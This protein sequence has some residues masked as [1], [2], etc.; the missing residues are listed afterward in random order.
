MRKFSIIF[1]GVIAFGALFILQ[2]TYVSAT[3]APTLPPD[4]ELMVIADCDAVNG[5]QLFRVNLN[6]EASKIGSPNLNTGGQC[7]D[8]PTYNPVTKK[9][10]FI[11]FS[12]SA[13]WFKAINVN[14]VSGELTE[15]S[16]LAFP[17][18]ISE[19]WLSYT[20]SAGETWLVSRDYVY[21]VDLSTGIIA[22]F[23]SL[24]VSGAPGV[25]LSAGGIDLTRPN[26][27][28]PA[29]LGNSFVIRSDSDKNVYYLNLD[30]GAAYT[31]PNFTQPVWPTMTCLDGSS[32]VAEPYG[33]IS[34]D[35]NGI[36]WML[37]SA[38]SMGLIAWNPDTGET[39]PFPEIRDASSPPIFA[40]NGG[41]FWSDLLFVHTI[42]GS[43][44]TESNMSSN[45]YG[46]QTNATNLL[47]KT[48]GF[49]FELAVVAAFMVFLGITLIAGAKNPQVK[50]Q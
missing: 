32:R 31:L 45:S 47:A 2:S 49:T 13:S 5:G 3:T 35:K 4:Q 22:S 20:N 18:G 42:V 14:T 1:F 41:S 10:Q 23:R 34:F 12:N 38:C 27:Y 29:V 21:K 11:Y 37:D 50:K 28:D 48:G 40:T 17:L 6:G 19:P 33:A 26:I 43:G 8:V 7:F 24:D 46:N 36:G 16:N 39:W 25:G 9:Y 15:A 30:S 44:S